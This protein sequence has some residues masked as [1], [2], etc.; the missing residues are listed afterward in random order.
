MEEK[1]KV[2]VLILNCTTMLEILGVYSKKENAIEAYQ[3]AFGVLSGAMNH[4]MIG[5]VERD[6]D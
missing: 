1:P 2:W 3:K 4:K 5:I 6:L